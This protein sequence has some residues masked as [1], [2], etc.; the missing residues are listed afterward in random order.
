MTLP[1]ERQ[2]GLLFYFFR[3]YT[4]HF[5]EERIKVGKLTHQVTH[6]FKVKVATG[7]SLHLF[8]A[9]GK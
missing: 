5:G 8:L 2:P 7:L 6:S 9:K 4:P 1:S 3:S